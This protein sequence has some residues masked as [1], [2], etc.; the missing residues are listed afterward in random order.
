MANYKTKSLILGRKGKRDDEGKGPVFIN[1]FSVNDPH[2][3]TEPGT[4]YLEFKGIQKIIIKEL[5]V[6]YLIGGSDLFINDLKEVEI[7]I[8]EGKP[9]NIII[10]GKQ[11]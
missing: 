7:E 10:T 9:E 6:N 4:K 3:T 11:D 8:Q 1:L 2:K 5:D